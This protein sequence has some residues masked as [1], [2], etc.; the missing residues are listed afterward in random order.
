MAM[1]SPSGSRDRL[2]DLP[3]DVLGHVLSFLPNKLAG[4]AAVLSRRWR[5]IFSSVDTISFEEPDGARADDRNNLYHESNKEEKKSRSAA[6]LD[7]VWSAILCRRRC[8]VDAHVPLRSFRVAF[9]N[10][11]V[12][13]SYHVDQWLSYVLRHSRRELHLDVRFR[14]GA[15]CTHHQERRK[16]GWYNLPRNLFSC[17]AMRSLGLSYCGLNLPAAIN[18]PFLETLRLTGVDHG[19]S[20]S[21]SIQR[22]IASCPRL[23]DL[24]LEANNK[25]EKVSVLGIRLRRFALRCCHSV[26]TVDIDVSELRS[27]DYTGTVPPESLLSLHGSPEKII[28]SCTIDFCNIHYANL[29]D[30]ARIVPFLEKISN[31]ERLHLHHRHIPFHYNFQGFPLFPNLTTLMLRGGN[32]RPDVVRAILEQTPNLE[33]LSLLMEFPEDLG[34]K[35]EPPDEASFS[36]PC[37]RHRVREINIIHYQGDDVLQSMMAKLLFRNALVLER[38]CVVLVKGSFELQARRKKEIETWVVAADVR[39]TFL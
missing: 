2:S 3:N 17:V 36:V 28:P 7:D 39:R 14:L 25:L 27:L 33:V 13:N 22:L 15:I 16:S 6:L 18:L 32:V 1:A 30:H 9:D 26:K 5:H 34:W 38:L 11:H 23:V 4:R 8:A 20:G 24:A 12:W 21:G 35:P 10:C 31:T 19:D 37:L 29:T